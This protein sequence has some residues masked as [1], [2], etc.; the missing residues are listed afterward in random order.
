MKAKIIKNTQTNRTI[1]SSVSSE[2]LDTLNRIKTP[3]WSPEEPRIKREPYDVPQAWMNN[4]LSKCL[5]SIGY[6]PEV[7]PFS[8]SRPERLLPRSKNTDK[9]RQAID[10]EKFVDGKRHV[11]EVEC[12]NVA[13]LYRSIHKIC[14][15]MKEEKNTI[16]IVIVPSQDLMK[17]CEPPSAMSTSTSAPIVLSEYEYYAPVAKD[18]IVIEFEI[19]ELIDLSQ[20]NSNPSFWKGNWSKR[21]DRYLLEENLNIFLKK[22]VR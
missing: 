7:N 4:V 21:Q 13:S 19:D 20:I 11:I 2:L 6:K 12:G 1:E 14:M 17:R 10:F 15:A 5:I 8:N 22:F 3:Y 18:I 9:S 16:G